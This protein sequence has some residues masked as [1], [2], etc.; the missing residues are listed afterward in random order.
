MQLSCL[1]CGC[2]DQGEDGRCDTCGKAGFKRQIVD[3]FLS[4]E[5]GR[6]IGGAVV[7]AC[8]QNSMRA[9]LHLLKIDP[10]A[11]YVEG[12]MYLRLVEDDP[13]YIPL[14]HGWLATSDGRIVDVTLPGDRLIARYHPGYQYDQATTLA[15]LEGTRRRKIRFPL[16]EKLAK[17]DSDIQQ[18][19]QAQK[20]LVYQALLHTVDADQQTDIE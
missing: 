1:Y 7:K 2:F 12:W 10:A 18:A 14:E 17:R 3:V 19:Y 9:Y 5:L 13:D 15:L 20:V 4:Q 6:A 11:L 8:W 16:A